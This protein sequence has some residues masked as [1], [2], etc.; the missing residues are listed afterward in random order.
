MIFLILFYSYFFGC[1]VWPP[2]S[3]L[4]NQ[5]LNPGHGS[6]SLESQPLGHQGTSLLFVLL[7]NFKSSLY[8]L[9]NIPLSDVSF[10]NI[11]SQS[12]ACLLIFLMLSFAE[13]KFFILFIYLFGLTAWLVDLSSLTR[14]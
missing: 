5:G 1:T 11:F 4:P 6:E 7:L 8:P 9:D 13:Q 12:V 2:G 14:D 10:A 3:Q